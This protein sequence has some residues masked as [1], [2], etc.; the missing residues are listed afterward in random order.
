MSS[1]VVE[2]I[3]RG[4]RVHGE[5]AVHHPRALT[6]AAILGSSFTSASA[7]SD[8][9]SAAERGRIALTTK[10]YLPAAWSAAAY[11]KAGRL[12]EPPGPD[13]E[14]DANDY[15][16]AFR[17]RYGLHPAPYPNNDLPMGL[18]KAWSRDGK[19]EGLQIDCMV[20][21]GGSIG[22]TSLVGLGNTQLDLKALLDD[23]TVADGKKLPPPLF[24]LNSARGTMNA[25]QIAVV[26]L[27][28]RDSN[29]SYRTFPMLTGASLPELD[30]PAWW[31]LAKKKTQYYDGRTDARSAR[32]NM[33]F[34]LG[35][36]SLQDFKDLEST[37]EDIQAYFRSL[38][39]PKY[40]FPIDGAR[41]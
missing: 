1:R 30:V 3:A 18:R 21:H 8:P 26:L 23:L 25:G 33:Q 4:G 13:P 2:T 24:T 12:W 10:G 28:F 6:C 29:L 41:R 5:E 31:L 40:P 11:N 15:P 16:A 39:P 37:F 36:F 17:A 20:C 32:S 9:D 38:K 35:D 34:F 7:R 22:G 19:R 14:R 27:S